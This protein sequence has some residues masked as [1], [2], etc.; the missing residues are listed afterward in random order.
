M[1]GAA[2]AQPFTQDYMDKFVS[3]IRHEIVS[4]KVDFKGCT[5]DLHRD[6]RE[7]GTQVDD[8]ECTLD[9]SRKDKEVLWHRITALEDQQI[10]HQAKQEDLENH[11][12]RKK[13]LHPGCSSGCEV[14]YIMAFTRDVTIRRDTENQSL[15]LDRAYHIAAM[16]GHPD[17]TPN[18]L[19]RVHF[20]QEMEAILRAARG[21]SRA[22]PNCETHPPKVWDALLYYSWPNFTDPKAAMKISQKYFAIKVLESTIPASSVGGHLRNN[23]KLLFTTTPNVLFIYYEAEFCGYL[24]GRV[25]PTLEK[26]LRLTEA[27]SERP[28]LR[29]GHLSKFTVPALA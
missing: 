27:I 8:L 15:L 4:R 26:L 29:Q 10:E 11:S 23:H 7:V 22:I 18:I 21:R 24:R 2:A 3:D 1:P 14:E 9:S 16:A 19:T 28:G 13:H 17:A 25:I 20:F 5:Q 6:I 12:R